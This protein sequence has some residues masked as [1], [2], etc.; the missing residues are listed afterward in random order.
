MRTLASKPSNS[1]SPPMS[2][3]LHDQR[4]LVMHRLIA[5]RLRRD[6]ALRGTALENLRRWCAGD[7]EVSASRRAAALEWR[8]LLEGPLP[9]LLHAMTAASPEGQRL[10][11]SS[12]FAGEVFIRQ[13]ERLRVLRKHRA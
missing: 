1:Y 2:H 10:R 11:Q 12:P 8:P 7:V 5:R 4:S 6:P 9:R 3:V 13:P